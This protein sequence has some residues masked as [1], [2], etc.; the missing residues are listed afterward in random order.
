[1]L[2]L[3]LLT[4]LLGD[5]THHPAGKGAAEA[6]LLVDGHKLYLSWIEARAK[7]EGAIRFASYDGTSWSETR[8]IV[9][10]DDLFINWTDFQRLMVTEDFMTAVWPRRLGDGTYAYG[11][12]FARSTDGGRSWS[13]P[14][15]LHEDRQ[16]M[17]HGFVSLVRLPNGRVGACW[18]DG[19]AMK[20]KGMHLMY[21]EVGAV[22]L[23]PE[24]ILDA[25]V[26]ECCM[27]DMV[28]ADGKP[29]IAYRD[30]EAD[31]V[32]DISLM[33]DG[34]RT[35][36]ADDGWKINGCP[37][38]GPALAVHGDTTAM[39]W[40]TLA[41]GKARIGLAVGDAGG[42]N[43]SPP[44]RF[45]QSTMGRLDL[46]FADPQT[47]ALS[48]LDVV[49]DAQR[50]MLGWFSAKGTP[51]QIALKDIDGVPEGRV[52]G[53]PRLTA[54]NGQLVLAYQNPDG[55][56]IKLKTLPPVP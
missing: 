45:S 16:P 51:K 12:A 21:R 7:T 47:L 19:R 55:S 26:C 32:R 1:M 5:L 50:L 18:L 46:V 37:V 43:W 27:T 24:T 44:L 36:V 30:R 29:L 8:T 52:A 41:P 11:L 34:K 28:L 20:T 4:T 56:G 40:F 17:E 13:A 42:A 9:D 14:M 48:W 33:V 15:W 22:D 54:Y 31:E 49:D 3:F 38:N 2:A 53:V 23:G 35:R 10:A 39:A 6:S 25:R